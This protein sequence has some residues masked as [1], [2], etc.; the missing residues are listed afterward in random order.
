MRSC[1]LLLSLFFVVSV[2]SGASSE[3][4]LA[5]KLVPRKVRV[6]LSKEQVFVSVRSAL[7]PGAV[8]ETSWARWDRN[9]DGSLDERELEPLL[10]ELR[11]LEL[12]HLGVTVDGAVVPVVRLVTKMETKAPVPLDA[13]LMVRFEGTEALSL[14]AGA[15][16][17]SVYDQPRGRDGVV[18][19]RISFGRGL[20]ATGGGGARAELR[21]GGARIEVATTKN[22]P[23]FWGG[24]VREDEG[25]PRP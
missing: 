3:A 13:E 15:H 20:K 9:G 2:L 24:F 21:G 6:S 8:G 11:A 4:Q 5:A 10:R 18:P 22:A 14:A 17:L 12:G 16:R 25:A 19:F 1:A 7:Q 23:I